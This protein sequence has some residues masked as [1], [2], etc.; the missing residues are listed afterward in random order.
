VSFLKTFHPAIEKNENWV[1]IG[2]IA[3]SAIIM[4]AIGQ[5]ALLLVLAGAFNGL[6]LP[7]T[8]GICLIASQKKSIV[9]ESYHHPVWL[10][11]L[12]VIVVIISAYLGINTFVSQMGKLFI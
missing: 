4:I 1:I 3:V 7:I 2:F 8:L 12:G 6:I 11:I 9:G 10:L 5:P